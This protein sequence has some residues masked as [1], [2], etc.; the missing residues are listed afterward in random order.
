MKDELEKALVRDFPNVFHRDSNGI[1]CWNLFG[2]EF[3]DGW[4]PSLR[5]AAAKLE[6]LLVEQIKKDPEGYKFGYYRTTQLKEK[7]GTGRWYTSGMTDEM[8]KITEAWE[9]RTH[10]ICETCGKK[11][12]LRG[13]SW[14]Y[15]ACWDHTQ[16][17]DRDNLEIVEDA[18]EKKEKKE[19]KERKNG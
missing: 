8:D 18:Y 6:P 2:I 3:S 10:K 16:P 11:G 12:K 14:V 19:K 1:D 5:K 17:Q 4:E 9:K 13:D 7:F 15:T